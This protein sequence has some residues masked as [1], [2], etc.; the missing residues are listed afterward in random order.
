MRF[1]NGD[2]ESEVIMVSE[3]APESDFC[4]ALVRV[5]V[6]RVNASANHESAKE[7]RKVQESRPAKFSEDVISCKSD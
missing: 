1:R 7:G 5:S 2:I 4:S 3:L 6:S